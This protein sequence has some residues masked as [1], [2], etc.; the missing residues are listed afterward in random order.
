MD[1]TLTPTNRPS[2]TSSAPGS[3]RTIPARA[4]RATRCST[5]SSASGSASCTPRLGRRLVAEGVRRPRRDPDRA[6]DLRRGAGAREGAAAGERARAR[7]GRPG[8]DRARDRGAEGALPGAD[9]LRRGDLVPGLLR[10][11]VGLRPRLA[12]DQGGQG[13]RRLA[14]HRP[15]G[16]DHLRPRGE[17]VHAGRPHRPRRA[18]AQG[19]HLLPHGHGAGRGRGPAAAPDHR[20]VGVQRAVHRERL[21]PR[22]E[23][24]RRG[25]QRLDGRDHDAD[26]RARRARRLGRARPRQ[27]ARRADRARE[28]SA[29]LPTT[30]SSATRSRA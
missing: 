14:D 13:E 25:R 22:R 16:V 7:D 24:R 11:R 3:R 5:S 9:P 12:E 29:A 17:V 8:R 10:A 27:R 26:E 30:R 20:R 1:L 21:R 18:Q 28:A 23:R 15:E 2:A 6:V 4:R 19:P